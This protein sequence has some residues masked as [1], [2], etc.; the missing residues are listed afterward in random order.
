[1]YV[2][3]SFVVC[4]KVSPH[5]SNGSTF[6]FSPDSRRLSVTPAYNPFESSSANSRSQESTLSSHVYCIISLFPLFVVEASSVHD[7]HLGGN[8]FFSQINFSNCSSLV[9]TAISQKQTHFEFLFGYPSR[10]FCFQNEIL[11]TNLSFITFPSYHMTQRLCQAYYAFT[12]FSLSTLTVSAVTGQPSSTNLR[13]TESPFIPATSTTTT[14][15][16][17]TNNNSHNDNNSNGNPLHS[18]APTDERNG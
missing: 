10:P 2:R 16:T 4:I 11:G 7:A 9:S 17:T 12:V 1:M 18:L 8:P 14:T 13:L 15:T 3:R 6:C 5:L